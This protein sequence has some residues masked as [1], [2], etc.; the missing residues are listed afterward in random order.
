MAL[1]FLKLTSRWA[2]ASPFLLRSRN[3]NH[4]FV[5][6]LVTSVTHQSHKTHC[7]HTM[8]RSPNV[9][10]SEGS[11]TPKS[12]CCVI[13]FSNVRKGAQLTWGVRTQK[14]PKEGRGLTGRGKSRGRADNMQFLAPGSRHLITFTL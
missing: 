9:M 13:P 10:L 4:I 11:Q 5:L 1:L 14:D 7:T 8:E 3:L 12:M 6:F 2:V